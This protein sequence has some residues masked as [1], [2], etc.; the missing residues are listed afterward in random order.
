[1]Y[2]ARD[3]ANAPNQPIKVK[4]VSNGH[5]RNKAMSSGTNESHP[6]TLDT[7]SLAPQ[8]G[9]TSVWTG[10]AKNL[11]SAVTAGR[12]QAGHV[13]FMSGTIHGAYPAAHPAEP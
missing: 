12:P 10:P 6:S 13:S 5:V 1:M 2:S 3:A 4:G 9:Q 11:R 7:W 8:W